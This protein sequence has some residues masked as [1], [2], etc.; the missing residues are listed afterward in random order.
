MPISAS[1]RLVEE[2]TDEHATASSN[3]T[4]ALAGD[5]LA[6]AGRGLC[7]RRQTEGL[8]TP[9]MVWLGLIGMEDA[10]RPGMDE[11]MAEFH[12]AGVRTVMITGDQSATAYSVGHRLGCSGDKPLEII[13]SV[14]PRQARPGDS[15]GRHQKHL[16]V[17]PRQPR[18]QAADRAGPAAGRARSW[19]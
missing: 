4:T 16:G 6:R 12:S 17:R 18:P 14:Q 3:A 7:L 2:L 10:L 19:R 5:A 1:G 9:P 13:D 15:E 8:K 11:L